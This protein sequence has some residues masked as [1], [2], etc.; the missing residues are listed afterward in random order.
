[1]DEDSPNHSEKNGI[2][3]I[4]L[5]HTAPGPEGWKKKAVCTE[6]EGQCYPCEQRRAG[7]WEN[8]KKASPRLYLNV[9]VN[10]GEEDEHVAILSQ[11]TSGKSITPSLLAYAREGSITDRE[12][13]ISRSGM[14]TETAWT[15]IARDKKK[16]DKDIEDYEVYNLDEVAVRHV[17]YDEQAEFYGEV[18]GAARAASEQ[19]TAEKAKSDFETW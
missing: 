13:K 15:A 17:P 6:D 19:P 16:F 9:L 1:L 10:P 4:A 14:K 8:W 2:G 11:G 12:W 18:P 3:F 5:E 7:D